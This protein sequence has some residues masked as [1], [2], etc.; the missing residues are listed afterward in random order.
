MF[1]GKCND[2][3]PTVTVVLSTTNYVFGGF[4]KQ[5]WKSSAAYVHDPKAFIFSL[6]HKTKHNNQKNNNSIYTH[7]SYGP[8][9]GGGNDIYISDNC[10][11][12]NF[13][14][15]S[16]NSTYEL[17]PNTNGQVYFAGAYNFTVKEIEVY[18]VIVN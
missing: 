18:A 5:S 8:T 4:T 3:G 14:Y 11:A 15:S 7:P 6:N 1:H 16:S 13:S 2:Q 10:N 17:P 12:N 9:F